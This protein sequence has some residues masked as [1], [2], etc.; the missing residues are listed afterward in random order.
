M[1]EGFRGLVQRAR[2]W[3]RL[4]KRLRES[5]LE[6]TRAAHH[7][8][9]LAQQ[10]LE[11]AQDLDAKYLAKFHEAR[12]W[13]NVADER[14]AEIVRLMDE[15]DQLGYLAAFL[16]AK[17]LTACSAAEVEILDAAKAIPFTPIR[18]IV[19][20]RQDSEDRGASLPA[21][22]GMLSMGT[23]GQLR[24]LGEAVIRWRKTQEEGKI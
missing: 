12:D 5:A 23:Q 7:W 16:K 10:N 6:A 14:S 22:A 4:A 2:L 1:S 8:R 13:H 11:D 20:D 3:K 21:R 17:Q 18:R 15:R 9:T 19:D 24:K